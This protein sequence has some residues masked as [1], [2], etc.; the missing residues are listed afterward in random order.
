MKNFIKIAVGITLLIGAFIYLF[1]FFTGNDHAFK[2]ENYPFVLV[3]GIC[4]VGIGWGFLTSSST[5]EIVRFGVIG[6]S[7]FV[8]QKV[9]A[10]FFP[11]YMTW[12][13]EEFLNSV[14]EAVFK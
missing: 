10:A 7:L 12:F 9:L 11:D 13:D 3:N 4:L 14:L 5:E 6:V 8:F 1:M 2:L